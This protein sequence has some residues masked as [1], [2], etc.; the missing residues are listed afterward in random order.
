MYIH[1]RIVSVY[2]TC[3][4]MYAK[5]YN[6]PVSELNLIDL[7]L[8]PLDLGLDFVVLILILGY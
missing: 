5:C 7:I 6:I 8:C 4:Y 2:K 3:N 1:A